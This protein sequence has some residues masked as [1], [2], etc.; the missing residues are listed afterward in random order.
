MGRTTN[1]Q[2]RE[3][4]AVTAR[5]K[6]AT[7]RAEQQRLAQRRR[8]M[9]VLSSVVVIALVAALAAY[10]GINHHGKQ[11]ASGDR[12][13]A[14][15]SVV[16]Q[17]AGVTPATLQTIGAGSD[18]L[19][20]KKISDPPL[21]SNGKPEMLFIGAEFCP[22]CGAERWPMIQALSRFGKFSNLNQISSSS[23]DTDPNTPTFSFYKSSYTSKYISFVP[24]ED[25]TRTQSALEN[26]T[27]AQSKLWVKYTGNPPGFPFIDYGGKFVQTSQSFD[28]SLLAGMTQ[29]QVAAQLNNPNSKVAKAIDGGANITTATLCTLTNNQPASVCL[30]PVITTLQSQIGA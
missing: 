4:Q 22:F 25:E 16:S 11:S 7:A 21:T 6:A 14:S 15:D 20:P 5:E 19:A 12:V 24:V 10:I 9:T 27:A 30:T 17:V 2:R 18:T 29:A 28:P 8:A 1:K 23:T 3:K 26:P 13:I